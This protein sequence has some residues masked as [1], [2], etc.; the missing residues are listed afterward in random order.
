MNQSR[1]LAPCT[2]RAFTSPPTFLRGQNQYLWDDKERKYLDLFGHNM[3]V[4]LGHNHHKVKQNIIKQLETLSHCS[5]VFHHP[6]P[7]L[8]ADELVSTLPKHPSGEEWRVHLTVTGSEAVDLAVEMTKVYT[9]ESVKSLSGSYHGLQGSARHVTHVTREK[10]KDENDLI[11]H[12]SLL[13]YNFGGVIYEPIQ[14][15]GGVVKLCNSLISN[16]RQCTRV[17]IADEIQTGVGR[18]G[19][20]MWGFERFGIKNTPDIMV[21]AKG[22]GNGM[23]LISAVIARESISEEF[24]KQSFFNTYSGNPVACVAATTVLKTIKSQHLIDHNRMCGQEFKERLAP[25]R[26]RGSGL[27]LGLEI[28]TEEIAKKLQTTLKDRYGIIVGRGGPEGNIIRIQPPF[29]INY[30]D[31]SDAS[32]AIC[33][34][35]DRLME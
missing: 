6:A 15:Y 20:G 7:N 31:I 9:G 28:E 21:T 16:L 11:V 33:F 4:S 5:R 18:T 17:M 27:M 2:F 29:S 12:D 30:Q 13:E 1:Y 26:V 23:G 34:T 32:D 35:L 14:G 25:H 19:E 3:C 10:I 8:L 22:L 24:S